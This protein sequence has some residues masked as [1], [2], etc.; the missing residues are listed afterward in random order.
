MTFGIRIGKRFSGSRLW[1]EVIERGAD[2]LRQIAGLGCGVSL[3][4]FG[5]GYSSLAYLRSLPIDCLK[6]D[7]SFVADMQDEGGSLR[8]VRAILGLAASIGL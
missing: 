8:I 5:T 6:I 2:V 4:D 3:D 1:S 7:R